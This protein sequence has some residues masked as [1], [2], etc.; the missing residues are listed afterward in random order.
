MKK[1]RF[2][3]I[4]LLIIIN[5][6]LGGNF[7]RMILNDYQM[8]QEKN[9][10]QV[11]ILAEK[12]IDID[13]NILKNTEINAGYYLTSFALKENI[14]SMI[15]D[16]KTEEVDVYISEIA[17]AKFDGNDVDIVF[18]ESYDLQLVENMLLSAGIILDEFDKETQ[19]NETTYS[20]KIN[21]S[22][23]LNLG[24]SVT[25]TDRNTTISGNFISDIQKISLNYLTDPFSIL[26]YI[27]DYNGEVTDIFVVHEFINSHIIPSVVITFENFFIKFDLINNS[28]EEIK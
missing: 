14:L 3:L 23:V 16:I 15:G 2:H 5:I 1:M 26:L 4:I 7:Y 19:L 11:E 9:E 17:S 27:D 22:T 12:G 8:I 24:F 25:I 20:Y 21:D 18:N 6:F 28:F 13:I 10:L